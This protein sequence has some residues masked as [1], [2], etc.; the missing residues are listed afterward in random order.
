M[1]NLNQFRT[2]DVAQDRLESRRIDRDRV[3]WIML[4]RVTRTGN[5][6][7]LHEIEAAA[8]GCELSFYDFASQDTDIPCT[9]W[10]TNCNCN[11]QSPSN[12]RAWRRNFV[13]LFSIGCARR[14]AER[15]HTFSCSPVSLYHYLCIRKPYNFRNRYRARR[16][17][18]AAN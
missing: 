5:Y 1:S 12:A 8:R 13:I 14:I 17:L 18:P 9:F 11:S 4:L 10:N 7:E 16:S 15:N 6:A 2:F 3:C